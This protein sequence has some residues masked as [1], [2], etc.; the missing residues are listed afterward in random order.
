MPNNERI[1][2]PLVLAMTL[3]VGLGIVWGF[4]AVWLGTI[5]NSIAPPKHISRRLSVLTDGTPYLSV[6]QRGASSQVHNLDGELVELDGPESTINCAQLGNGV[7]KSNRWAWE[8]PSWKTRLKSFSVT[9][10]ME[11]SW[12]F[13]HDG[14]WDGVGYFV[15][16]DKLNKECLGFLGTDG[17]EQQRPT[18]ERCFP[19]RFND[20]TH[21][22][23]GITSAQTYRYPLGYYAFSDNRNTQW[24]TWAVAVR[25]GPKVVMANLRDKT[26]EPL[27]ENP[28]LVAVACAQG[29]TKNSAGHDYGHRQLIAMRLPE[30]IA[31]LSLEGEPVSEY[32]I[33]DDLRTEP[34]AVYL[35]PD[36]KALFATASNDPILGQETA[37]LIWTAPDGQELDR[38][39]VTLTESEPAQTA[40]T[41]AWMAV[42]VCPAPGP[43]VP[44]LLLGLGPDTEKRRHPEW[45]FEQAF[46]ESSRQLPP[47][48]LS[49]VVLGGA[50][51]WLCVRR[52]RKY[53]SPWTKTWAT[54]VFL[55]G[56]PGYLAYLCHRRWPVR[57]ECTECH[58][59]AP[60]D[61][62]ACPFCETP[63][64][65]PETKGIEVFA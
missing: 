53:S 62:D 58:E 59:A 14:R 2:R 54:F 43:L 10:R 38:K 11:Q 15:G 64:P 8:P 39:E 65:E 25:M 1:G 34:L 20:Y 51:S 37:T 46:R 50:M 19:L 44:V 60:Q 16:Y 33:P 61:R 4:L 36:G 27:F 22:G 26:V 63:Y 5:A 24:P 13:I 30:K 47:V 18:Q 35:I 31:F 41:A 52:Q 7:R 32:A 42:G 40:R 48:L 23:D 21:G 57:E 9:G 45:T 55:L 29:P 12:Y 17:W 3:T 6:Y 56:I 49:L 28:D